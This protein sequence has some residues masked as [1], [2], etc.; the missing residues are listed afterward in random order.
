ME[1]LARST[2]YGHKAPVGVYP[3]TRSALESALFKTKV[4]CRVVLL[5]SQAAEVTMGLQT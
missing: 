5:P 1:M 2:E 4:R 3:S